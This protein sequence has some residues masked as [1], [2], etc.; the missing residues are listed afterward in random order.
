MLTNNQFSF[1]FLAVLL[2]FKSFATSCL[3][4]LIAKRQVNEKSCWFEVVNLA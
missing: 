1:K 2:K 3:E 4:I